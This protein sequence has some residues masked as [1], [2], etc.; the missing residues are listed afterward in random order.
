M[1]RCRVA[2]STP[3]VRSSAASEVYKGQDEEE[4]DV[5]QQEKPT[6]ASSRVPSSDVVRAKAGVKT[7]GVK[8]AAAIK[9]LMRELVKR[10]PKTG[11]TATATF[12]IPD[13]CV[14]AYRGNGME[15]PA[16]VTLSLDHL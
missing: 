14:E 15:A 7:F 3:R 13:E 16:S 1:H 4:T 5:A 8:S 2:R 9:T 10:N 11:G 12:T 6:G